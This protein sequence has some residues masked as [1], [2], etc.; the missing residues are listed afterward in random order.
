MEP[1]LVRTIVEQLNA[2]FQAM[3]TQVQ[4]LNASLTQ[5]VQNV[6]AQ[7]Q[8]QQQADADAQRN[9]GGL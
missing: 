1:D 3:F 6:T 8:Q 7:Q 9:E 2:Q 4:D 5:M